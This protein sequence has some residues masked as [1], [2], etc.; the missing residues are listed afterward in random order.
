MYLVFAGYFAAEGII[1]P[2]WPTWLASQHF[3]SGQIGLL[4]A[5]AYWPQIVTGI[6]L[7]YIADWHVDQLR[8]AAFLAAIASGCTLLFC[9]SDGL[10]Q[11]LLL[12]IL[13]GGAWTTVLPLVESFLL[14]RD[15]V[16]MQN[17]GWVRAVGSLAFIAAATF[18]GSLIN[19]VGQN[20][21]PVL[22]ASFM[23]MTSVVC[24]L[25]HWRMTKPVSVTTEHQRNRP[26]LAAI[27]GERTLILA[28]SAAA[29]IQI[30]H[31]L[32]FTTSSLGWQ[33]RG[34]SPNA[35]GIFWALAVLAE[36]GFFAVSSYLLDRIPALRMILFSSICASMR[37]LFFAG[38]QPP[39]GMIVLGQCM[40]ALSFA[41]YHAAVIRYIRDNAPEDAR[42]LT[43]GIY[44]SLAVALPMG[45]ASPIAGWLHDRLASLA[46][47]VMTMLAL[48]GSVF[49]LLAL[50]S[51]RI[52]QTELLGRVP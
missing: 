13:Y 23:L 28:I 8:L 1:Y 22:V 2:F 19:H 10:V 14:K 44:Y 39:T 34:Y 35:V 36:I 48:L 45:I 50:R 47:L 33:A 30:S 12:G 27:L 7:T 15:K 51:A 9:V 52:V 16:S 6:A 24:A 46:Y 49:A 37:W 17:Y 21:V 38:S 4:I 29:F 3:D 26:S 20:V 40:H 5:A 31:S 18:G 25:L 32:Y 41:A 43:Q 11:Y 42:A